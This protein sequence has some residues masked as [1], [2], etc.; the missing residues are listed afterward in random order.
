MARVYLGTLGAGV[1]QD[2]SGNVQA[3]QS[4]TVKVKATGANATHYSAYTGGSSSTASITTTASG[5]LARWVD[6][7]EKY[8]V[9]VGAD[10]YD[11]DAIPGEDMKVVKEAP[12]NVKH[13]EYGALGDG[14]DDSV[15]A[16]AAFAAV[17]GGK[18]YYPR[19]HYRLGDVEIPDEGVT[20]IGDGL[21]TPGDGQGTIIEAAGGATYALKAQG[22]RYLELRDLVIDGNNRASRGLLYEATA[23]ATGQSLLMSRVRFYQCTRGWHVGPGAGG[24]NQ[25]DKNT[26]INCDAISCDYGIYQEAPN[27]QQTVLV[28]CQ[29]GGTYVADIYMTGGTLQMIGGQFQTAAAA[30]TKGINLAGFNIQL[31]YLQHVIFEGPEYDI[32]DEG[33]CWPQD[34]IIADAV[35]F[36]GTGFNVNLNTTDAHLTTRHC[37]FNEN[38]ATLGSGIISGSQTGTVVTLAHVATEPVVTGAVIPRVL[39]E[40]PWHATVASAATI[41]PSPGA[42]TV[43]V[44]GSTTV[45]SITAQPEGASLTLLFASTAQVTDGSN[46]LLAG[47]FTGGSGRTLSL[48]SDGTNWWET[49]RSA[50]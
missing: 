8:T 26:L 35:S 33:S 10:T 17:N 7:P 50:N 49:G 22:K 5:V 37:R 15:A 25:A 27:S 46:L 9:T 43:T 14:S 36:Q 42:E 44:T 12:L 32:Y 24:I 2:A 41:S 48:R 45:T 3:G 20:I 34:G 4:A 13:K 11:F 39:R 47:N 30:G 40:A 29:F 19:G 23:S 31:V 6:G 16:S 38:P 18:I 28:N 21:G 1:L